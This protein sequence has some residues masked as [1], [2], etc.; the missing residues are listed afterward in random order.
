MHQRIAIIAHGRLRSHR[1]LKT[2]ATSIGSE[3]L[4][5]QYSGHASKLS[6]EIAPTNDILIVAGG[7]GSVNE[8]VNGV[9]QHERS[10]RPAVCI[11][12]LGSGND[13]ARFNGFT[14]NA[15]E[16]LTRLNADRRINW[17][18]LRIAFEI[19]NE[20]TNTSTNEHTNKLTTQQVRYC[21]NV[22]SIGLG[23]RVAQ[24]F[25]DD[26]RKLPGHAGYFVAILRGFSSFK[27]VASLLT[28]TMNGSTKTISQKRLIVAMCNS[29]YFGSGLGIAP[30][31]DPTDGV[32]EVVD[33]GEVGVLQYLRQLPRL[34]RASPLQDPR[35]SYNKATECRLESE[36][37]IPIEIDGDFVGTT[38]MRVSI[39]RH[40]IRFL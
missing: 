14:S 1:D 38:P 16:V 15:N 20:H 33:I 30:E 12:P 29:R 24:I 3:I 23:G 22:A 18:V 11:V 7:D 6:S 2:L 27:P 4:F 10:L 8:V 21:V 35:I 19:S 13:I 36:E 26:L 28:L 39:E 5:T 40:A 17:D 9:M 32:I 25:T 34:R 31:A 37:P